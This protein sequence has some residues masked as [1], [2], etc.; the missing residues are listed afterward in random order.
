MTVAYTNIIP[1]QTNMQ[2]AAANSTFAPK[3]GRAPSAGATPTDHHLSPQNRP[4]QTQQPSQEDWR[5]DLRTMSLWRGGPNTRTLPT[6]LLTPSA[7]KA[8]DMAHLCVPQNQALGVCRGF[9]PD[10]QI[11]GTHGR[12]N[13]VNATIISNA[14]EEE[15]LLRAHLCHRRTSSQSRKQICQW[16]L[17]A[18]LSATCAAGTSD[19]HSYSVF[20]E[21]PESTKHVRLWLDQSPRTSFV[22]L[23][24]ALRPSNM[25]VYLRDGSAQTIYVLPHWD[26]SCRSNFLSHPV[27]VYW[28]RADQSQC[29]PYNARRLAG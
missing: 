8:A 7:S 4:L 28:H 3:P 6:V 21:S 27:T 13:L 12:K 20:P 14:E 10:I 16:F 26:R 11:C 1:V 15:V 17:K 22:C 19:L 18:S 5:K 29:W 24:V 9:A 2:R 23:L 25:P